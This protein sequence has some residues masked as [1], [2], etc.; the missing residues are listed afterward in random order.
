VKEYLDFIKQKT[1]TFDGVGFEAKDLSSKLFDFQAAIVQWACKKGRAAIFADTGLGKT[2]MQV[3]WADQVQ[4]HTS[5]NI[6]IVAPLCVAQQTTKEAKKFK[7]EIS[8]HRKQPSEGGIHI[9]NYEMLEHFDLSSYAGLVLDESSILK[10]QTGSTRNKIIELSAKTPYRLSCTATPSPNDFME[11]G[12][13]SEFLGIM[14]YVEMLSTYF[15]HDGGETQKWILKGHAKTKFWEWLSSWAIFIKSPAD[16]GFDGSRYKLPK[17]NIHNHVVQA[18]EVLDGFLIPVQAESLQ[19]RNR[20]RKQTVDKRV[21]K[22]AEIVGDSKEPWLVWCH[23]NDESEKLAYHL[24]CPQVVGSDSVDKKE[25][26][27][28]A[29]TNGEKPRLVTK[30]SIAGFGMNWQHCSKMVFV[31]LSDSYEEIYQAIRR[32]YRFGQKREVDVHIVSADIEGA[33]AANIKRKEAQ[34]QEMTDAMIE[35]MREFQK[36]TFSQT[37]RESMEYKR[38]TTKGSGWTA[39]LG[40]CV[41]VAGTFENDSLDYSVFSPPFASLYTYSNSEFDMGNN[42]TD[43]GFYEQFRFLVKEL[44]RTLKP[45]RN[46]SFHCMNLPTSKQNHGF[47]GIRD[48]R[49]ELIRMFSEVGFIFHSEVCIWKDPVTAMQRTKAIGLLY[50]QLKKD[51]CISRQG[52]PDYLVTMRKPGENPNPVFKKP[53]NFP[54]GLWQKYASP[55]WMDINPSRTLNKKGAKE[56]D[57]EKHICP[58]QLDVIE[59]A[60]TLWTNPGDLVFSPFMGIGS[61]GYTAIKLGRRFV[62]SELKKSYFDQAVLNLKA[63][64][65][66]NSGLF[67]IAETINETQDD[68]A[69]N[70]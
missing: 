22:T 29:F 10:N 4:K 35:H 19:E 26:A 48:F 9:T 44:F 7:V 17:L 58:L 33:V 40:D 38:D 68:D 18:D 55:V 56:A 67:D 11:L 37:Q 45:G 69:A 52:I 46:I 53:E 3:S 12:N 21:A 14:R 15:T 32:C 62:G 47:I 36:K 16:I 1:K 60:I 49:G 54:V 5:G 30:P 20:A 43:D 13:Q 34:M 8:Y 31:G 59:R 63:A 61:E 65:E 24:E 39:I 70:E 6:L 23:L 42:K 27:I 2:A 41:E 66:Q 64:G 28:M 25:A 57:D 50:K 51:S